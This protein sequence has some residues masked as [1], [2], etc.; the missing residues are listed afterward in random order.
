MNNF[1][2]HSIAENQHILVVDDFVDNSILL[3]TLLELEGYQVEIANH[4]YVAINKIEENPPDIVL[5]D[6]IMPDIS[7]LA[8]ARWIRR[9]R[10]SVSIILMTGLDEIISF[11]DDKNIIDKV[12]HKPIDSDELLI[13]VKKIIN[14]P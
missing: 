11:E 7:G 9:N 8:V 10:P 12:I 4:G 5:L 1:T 3:A 6:L 13:L 14:S 2:S